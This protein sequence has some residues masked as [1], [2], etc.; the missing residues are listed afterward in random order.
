MSRC[1]FL[2]DFSLFNGMTS[3]QR[4]RPALQCELVFVCLLQACR[5][6]SDDYEQVRSAAVRMVWV[7][8][9]LYPERSAG[10][11]SGSVLALSVWV[12]CSRLSLLAAAVCSH[13]HCAHSFIERGDPAGGRCLR[14]DQSHGQRRL[15]DGSSASSQDPGEAQR[16]VHAHVRPAGL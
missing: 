6:L 7:L 1:V 16:A 13:Q 4:C 2:V 5:L 11:H 3:A 12:C 9:Q 15:L 14:E 10:D 8:S